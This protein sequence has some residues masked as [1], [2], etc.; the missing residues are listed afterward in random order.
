MRCEDIGGRRLCT[1]SCDPTTAIPLCPF[2][3]HC[4]EEACGMGRCVPGEGGPVP[5]GEPCTSAGECAS[6]RCV[7]VMGTMRCARACT[8]E[9]DACG[10]VELLCEVAAG[11]C[12]SCIPVELSTG[13]RPFGAVCDGD[14]D[15]ASGTCLDGF[16]TRACG[17]TTICPSM[18]HCRDRLCVRG[19][20]GG[21]GD[22]CVSS[23]D[24]GGSAPE[25]VTTS[26][27]DQLCAGP[28]DEMGACE[29]GGGLECAPTDA[30]DRCLPPGLALGEPCTS[31]DEC[32][33]TLCGGVCT[34]FCS[35]SDPCPSGFDCIM[36]GADHACA[37]HVEE[38]PGPGRDSGGC[39]STAGRSNHAWAWALALVAL[40]LVRR[41]RR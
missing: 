3:F 34:R 21:A 17:G 20:L 36:A 16:C 13:P 35:P 24:C 27:G 1:R 15:C 12:G 32:R 9:G 2:G 4:E 11:G 14:S 33:S 23:E 25:C 40:G 38:E 18:W 39:A 41:R 10:T 6:F 30:G 31:N 37:I 19:E 7:D 22:D 29:L 28:C 26:D 5:D 8:P